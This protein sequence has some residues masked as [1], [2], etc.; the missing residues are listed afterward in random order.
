MA[1]AKKETT[2]KPP[3]GMKQV[4]GI[5]DGEYSS[6]YSNY[7][8]VGATPFDVSI[9]FAEVDQRGASVEATPRIKVMMAPEQAANL[10]MMLTQALQQ[11][12]AQ[13]GPLRVSGKIDT[14][15]QI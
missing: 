15:N 3:S 4:Q 11:F 7:M 2:S 6:L 9:I 12:V 14:P 10:V 1:T 5:G 8:G 13:N